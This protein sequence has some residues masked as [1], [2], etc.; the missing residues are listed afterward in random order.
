[1]AAGSLAKFVFAMHENSILQA[2]LLPKVLDN[3]L[4]PLF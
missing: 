1:M 4:Q 3:E 2:F